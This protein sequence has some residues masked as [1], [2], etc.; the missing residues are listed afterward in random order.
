[1]NTRQKA[2]MLIL[3]TAL[4]IAL[5]LSG[6]C[7]YKIAVSPAGE[8]IYTLILTNIVTGLITVLIPSPLNHGKGV[9]KEPQIQPP[10]PVEEID[11]ERNLIDPPER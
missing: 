7:I 2:G 10:S 3:C 6:V 8:N 9:T 4:I 1:M 5:G 11:H